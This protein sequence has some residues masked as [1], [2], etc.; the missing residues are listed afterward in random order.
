MISPSQILSCDWSNLMLMFPIVFFILFVIF[1]SSQISVWFFFMIPSSLLNFSFCSCI[2]F[3]IL[4]NYLC[5]FSCSSVSFLKNTILNYFLVITGKLFSSSG[6]M[7]LW[8]FMFLKVLC[9]C[10]HIWNSTYLLQS[11]LTLDHQ[12]CQGFWVFLRPPMD[13]PSPHFSCCHVWQDS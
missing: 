6:V 9:F 4:W 8:F 13:T 5:V 1:F 12:P 10:L 7:F 11:L 2:V 3:L